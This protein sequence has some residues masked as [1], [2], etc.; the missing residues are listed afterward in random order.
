LQAK[1]FICPSSSLWGAPVLFVEKKDGTQQMCVDY[2]SLNEVTIKSKYPLPR[3]KDLFNQMKGD[4]VF[5]KIDL[6]SGYHQ[7]RIRELD[8]PKRAFHTWY[9]LYEY[10]MM[11]FGLMNAPTYFMYLMNNMFMEYLDKF[12]VVY[13][14]DSLVY[15]E[16]EEEH[17]EHLRLVSEKLRS[18]QLYAK[19]SKCE[20]WLTQVTFLVHVI[21]ARGVSVD[22]SKVR[23]VLNWKP[24]MGVSEIYSSLG[25]AGYYRRFIQDF[26]RVAKPMTQLHRWT[27]YSSGLRIA[28]TVLRN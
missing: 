12:V 24:P 21:S 18:N 23:D 1:G 9:G 19:F 26:S 25:L 5:Y 20:L 4:S 28:K 16:I 17:D 2:C 22:P 15:S 8:I 10:T 14:D 27:K 3:I 7:L 13:I 11:S 6:R